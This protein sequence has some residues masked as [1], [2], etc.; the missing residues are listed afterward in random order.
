MTTTSPDKFTLLSAARYRVSRQDLLLKLAM[1]GDPLPAPRPRFGQ[2][3]AYNKKPY[4][5]YRQALAW[6]LR[7][8]FQATP[9]L[10]LN[11]GTFGIKVAFYRRTRQRTDVDNLL[12][13]C[14]DAGTGI[15]WEDDSQVTEVFAQVH[16]DRAD[17]QV[18]LLVYRVPGP[19]ADFTCHWC[20]AHGQLPPSLARTGDNLRFFGVLDGIEHDVLH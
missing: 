12:K 11:G 10:T 20:G 7:A 9:R 3:Q 18:V 6:N 1:P 8:A 15:L 2:G 17:P 4:Q 13:T 19:T 16:V 5:I 14:L